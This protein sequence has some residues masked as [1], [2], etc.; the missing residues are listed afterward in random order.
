MTAL[1]I[2][3]GTSRNDLVAQNVQKRISASFMPQL[4]PTDGNNNFYGPIATEVRS[5]D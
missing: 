4:D 5:K 3:F 1:N 2:I